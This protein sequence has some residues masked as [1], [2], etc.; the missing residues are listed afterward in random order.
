MATSKSNLGFNPTNARQLLKALDASYSK[1]MTYISSAFADLGVVLFLQSGAW[2]GPDAVKFEREAYKPRLDTYRKSIVKTYTRIYNDIVALVNTWAKTTGSVVQ[3]PESYIGVGVP[4]EYKL[5]A[6]PCNSK[7]NVTIGN[8]LPTRVTNIKNKDLK[9]YNTELDRAFAVVK[10]YMVFLNTSQQQD[11][12]QTIASYNSSLKAKVTNLYDLAIKETTK[13]C[14]N[15]KA[16][17][18]KA[19]AALKQN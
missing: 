4:G 11:L 6:R 2:Y 7:G 1:T 9:Y 14:N 10:K 3:L 19:Q 5:C 15:Y 17:L 8:A 12:V 18:K 16:A 13:A